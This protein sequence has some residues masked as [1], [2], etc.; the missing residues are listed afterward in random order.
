[1]L[2][3]RQAHQALDTRDEYA[4]LLQEVLVVERDVAKPAAARAAVAAGAANGLSCGA[5]PGSGTLAHGDRH[6]KTPL[7]SSRDWE[8]HLTI[9]GRWN[10]IRRL[11]LQPIYRV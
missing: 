1:M 4:A 8:T 5:P 3:E 9:D 7:P 6:P 11:R 10:R 2:V